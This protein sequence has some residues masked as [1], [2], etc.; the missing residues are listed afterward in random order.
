MKPP[1]G[2]VVFVHFIFLQNLGRVSIRSQTIRAEGRFHA[3]ETE[4]VLVFS[5]CCVLPGL[6]TKAEQ[7][8]FLYLPLK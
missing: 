8:Q 7:E 4:K 5:R 1:K 3:S 6:K 2:V